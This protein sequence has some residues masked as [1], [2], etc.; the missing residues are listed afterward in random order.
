VTHKHVWVTFSLLDDVLTEECVACLKKRRSSWAKRVDLQGVNPGI[1]P[2][3][4]P[5]SCPAT[6]AAQSA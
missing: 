1:S 5:L 3:T 4:P 2:T 6:S